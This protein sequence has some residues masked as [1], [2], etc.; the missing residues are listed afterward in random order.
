MTERSEI[1]KCRIVRSE[2]RRYGYTSSLIIKCKIVVNDKNELLRDD[3]SFIFTYDRQ[4]I[5]VQ[6][7]RFLFSEIFSRLHPKI[8]ILIVFFSLVIFFKIIFVSTKCPRRPLSCFVRNRTFTR[9]FTVPD[10]SE[11]SGASVPDS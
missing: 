2:L 5:A 1:L 6:W 11:D 8:L 9:T 4:L 10:T 3:R 7:K